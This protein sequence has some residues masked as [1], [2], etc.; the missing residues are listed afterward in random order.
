MEATSGD[1]RFT[2]HRLS[3]ICL[4]S[5]KGGRHTSLSTSPHGNGE[6]SASR[7]KLSLHLVCVNLTSAL[8]LFAMPPTSIQHGTRVRSIVS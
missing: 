7:R 1:L 4:A 6:T 2:S 3:D 5:E 8:N